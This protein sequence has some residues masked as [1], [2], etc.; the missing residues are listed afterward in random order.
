[1]K[2]RVLYLVK[3]YVATVLIF[4]VAKVFFMLYH[5]DA[6]FTVGDIFDVLRHGLS[7]DLSTSLYLLTVPFL[8]TI[9]SLWV[10]IPKPVFRVY[11]FIAAVLLALAFV[12]DTSLYEFWK[13]KLD[14][15]CLQYLETPTEAMASVSTW[16][17]LFR[18]VVII[19]LTIAIYWIYVK[20]TPQFPK[21][22]AN[23]Q[24]LIATLI[25]LLLIP[26][27]VIGIRGG[28]DESTTNIG[29]VYYS[30]NQFLN[31]AA[32]NPVF[33]FF[34]SFE[35]TASNNVTYHFMDDK[36]CDEIVS[37]LYNTQSIDS[38]TLLTTQHPNIVIIL[39]ESCGGEFTEIGGRADITP[40]LSRLAREGIYFSNCYGNSW[41]TD[42]GT[43]CTWSGYPSFPTMSVMKIP[44]KSRSLPNIARTLKEQRDY[45]TYYIYGGD[46]NF[47]N[48]RSYLVSGGFET[49]KWKADYTK[50]EQESAQWGVRDDITLDTV[51]DLITDHHSPI[52]THHSPLLIGYST[53]SSHQPWDV[54][55]YHFDDEVYNSFYYLDQCIGNFIDKLRKSAVWDN[56]LVIMLP[57][58][59]FPYKVRDESDPL[60]N[61]IPMIWVGG[62]V[63]APKRIEQVCNQT[64]LPATLLGQLGINHDEYTFSRDVLSK[65]YTQPFAIHTYDDG[66]TMTDSVSFVNYDFISERVVI[67]Q[68]KK[69]PQLLQWGRAILQAASTDLNNR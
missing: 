57:D 22:T 29:Q 5:Y 63:K 11:Y 42:R 51:Y 27:M 54:P 2:E 49:L 68:G 38:D 56:I 53:L 15:S 43:V 33:S 59:G 30:Q 10:R 36:E 12:A 6:L 16:Y 61:H 25:A 20:I 45:Q 1:M 55:I 44:S 46:I 13:F 28:I 64:D 21:L 24:K 35:K 62:A 19:L 60:L 14:A 8:L 69:N 41:R 50:E 7:L 39:L 37:Q 32:V 17:I 52:T 66:Y 58:H 4:L 34:A 40:N 26:L 31:H 18:L 67:E 23:S 3:F 65:T 47:T 48:M 9:I